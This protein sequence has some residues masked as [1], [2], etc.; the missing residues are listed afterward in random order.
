MSTG[1]FLTGLATG[2]VLGILF[3]PDK[4]DET[5]KRLA[6]KGN[7]LK[8]TITSKL[9]SLGNEVSNEYDHAK[10]KASELVE[11]GKE[12]MGAMKTGA[13]NSFS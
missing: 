2:F 12:K 8:D 13:Q 4:G 6:Q 5:R 9:N 3:A 1:K 11:K 10:N 7:D